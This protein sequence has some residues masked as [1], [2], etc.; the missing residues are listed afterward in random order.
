MPY[1]ELTNVSIAIDFEDFD[2]EERNRNF[3]KTAGVQVP[4]S[5]EKIAQDQREANTLSV[6]YSSPA[7]IPF[8]PKEPPPPDADA[9]EPYE[10][11]VIFGEPDQSVLARSNGYFD[12]RAPPAPQNPTPPNPS[13]QV[14]ISSVLKVLQQNQQPQQPQPQQA[15]PPMQSSAPDL[16]S[17]FAQFSNPAQVQPI[18]QPQ[19]APQPPAAQGLDIQKLLAV[20]N[21]QKQ[22]QQATAFPQMQASQPPNLA[23]ILSQ[24]S[25]PAMQQAQ[26]QQFNQPQQFGQQNQYH[27]DRDRKR[28]H[29]SAGGYDGEDS[30][31]NY[32][33]RFRANGDS[34]K[35]KKHV[36]FL[37]I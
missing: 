25:N 15:Q 30:S 10:P 16:Q 8:S 2:P 6:F 14:D 37:K 36:S 35:N 27:E 13:S 9:D 1:D 4:E 28:H 19:Q 26:Q 34:S 29:E 32:N 18:P 3:V 20:M 21:A 23:A 33:K 31:Y 24:L 11:E 12:A 7:D 22:M 5:P 17:I